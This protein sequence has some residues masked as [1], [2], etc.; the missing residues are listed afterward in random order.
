MIA[1]PSPAIVERLFLAAQPGA[2]L[3]SRLRLP[4]CTRGGVLGDRHCGRSDWPGQN[5]TLVEAEEIEH[6]CATTGRAVDLALTRRNVVTRGVRLNDLVG[7]RFR[8]GD[9]LLLGVERCEPCRS[10]G[11]RLADE[12]LDLA[13][14][15]STTG[16]D[17]AACGPMC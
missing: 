10:L 7:R 11:L 3:Q 17:A 5:L 2:P 15:S 4:L 16:P 12:T 6:F 1:K 8:I 13:A 14:V 9:C